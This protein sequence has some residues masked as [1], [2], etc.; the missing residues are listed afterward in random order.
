MFLTFFTSKAIAVEIYKCQTDK[1][2]EIA[3]CGFLS[4]C[5]DTKT[6][7]EFKRPFIHTYDYESSYT[8]LAFKEK[9]I[10]KRNWDKHEFIYEQNKRGW[11][12]KFLK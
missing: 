1:R 3:M 7:K 5:I 9:L 10:V 8:V 12:T 11:R 2:T 4:N 6:K